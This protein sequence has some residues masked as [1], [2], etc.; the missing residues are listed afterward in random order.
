ML[1]GKL[2]FLLFLLS[3]L[4]AALTGSMAAVS[5]AALSGAADAVTLLISISGALCLWSGIMELMRCS[6][7]ADAL[8]RRLHPIL[9]LLLPNA[10]RDRET[11]SALA[12]N[13]SANL[14]GLGNAATPPGLKAARRMATGRNGQADD[15][16]C[17]LV[18]L[19]SCSL[20]LLPTTAAALRAAHGAAAPFD[21]LGAVWIASLASIVAGLGAAKLFSLFGRDR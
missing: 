2:L 10:S 18:V 13:L 16:L 21:I 12:A 9:R 14:L 4:S 3:L 11:L 7:T 19:N 17:R 1:L 6:G 8:S 15:E 5:A 20:Q